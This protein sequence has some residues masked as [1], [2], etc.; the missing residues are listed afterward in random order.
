MMPKSFPQRYQSD[1]Y[2]LS[3]PDQAR[4]YPFSIMIHL[5]SDMTAMQHTPVVRLSGIVAF[6]KDDLVWHLMADVRPVL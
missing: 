6:K 5:N 1:F 2:A 4:V 3:R